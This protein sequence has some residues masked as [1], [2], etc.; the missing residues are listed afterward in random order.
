MLF[1]PNSISVGF[2]PLETRREYFIF[3]AEK[4]DELNYT[5]FGLPETWSY[6]TML[7]LTEVALKTKQIKLMAGVLGIWGRSTA[8]IAMAATTLNMISEERFILGLGSSTKQLTEGF[9]DTSYTAPYK[10][11][12]QSLSQIRA[13]LNG[14]R[15]PLTDGNKAHPL[16]LGLQAQ[17]D[18][19][20]LL[21][22]SAS[23]SIRIAGELCDGWIPFLYPRDHLHTG[24]K[25]LHQ[26]AI[27][28]GKDPKLLQVCPSIPTVINEDAEV[29]RAGAA[30]FVAFYLMMMGPIYRNTLKR[31]GYENEV[32]AIVTANE[33]RKPEIVPPE[34]NSLLE[35]LT[36]YGTPAQARARLSKWYQAGA[37]MPGL[38]L[39]PNMT[40][41][42]IEYLLQALRP[43]NISHD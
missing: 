14:E 29:A 4:V 40:F 11:L 36:I 9:H 8:N 34:A 1:S 12:R 26:G 15:I 41:N 28:Q 30:W 7:T 18:L 35:Q 43:Q 39:A 22:A 42:E 24:I 13:L 20:I 3:M 5:A 2:M 19:P 17:P 21:G 10:K 31:L 33:S 23:K 38:V 37:T 32:A 25:L 27:Q 16:R 6:D